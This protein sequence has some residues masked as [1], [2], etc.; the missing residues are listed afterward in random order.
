MKLAMQSAAQSVRMVTMENQLHA[1]AERAGRLHFHKN[2]RRRAGLPPK[3]F[4]T[5]F[6]G[7]ADVPADDLEALAESLEDA[8]DMDPASEVSA[9]QAWVR[10]EILA[11]GAVG[12]S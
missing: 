2:A 3:R 4:F 6:A 5:R 1:A 9:L 7:F 12:G 8:L 10:R 11:R